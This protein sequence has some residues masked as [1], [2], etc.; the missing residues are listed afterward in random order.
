MEHHVNNLHTQKENY[1]RIVYKTKQ[2]S[3]YL[4]AVGVFRRNITLTTSTATNDHTMSSYVDIHGIELLL[5]TM[6]NGVV[7]PNTG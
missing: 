4:S 1:F 3:K 2:Y 6:G 7:E 5:V